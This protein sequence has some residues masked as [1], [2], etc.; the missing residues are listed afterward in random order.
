[1]YV[2]ACAICDGLVLSESEQA[3]LLDAEAC[4]CAVHV[5]VSFGHFCDSAEEVVESSIS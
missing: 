1:M 5:C 4:G 3:D 2:C